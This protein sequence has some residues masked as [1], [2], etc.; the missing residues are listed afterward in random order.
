MYLSSLFLYQS[1][2]QRQLL[3]RDHSL[4]V[5]HDAQLF[6]AAHHQQLQQQEEALL[7]LQGKTTRP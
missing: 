4:R 3:E 7:R 2:S 1:F 6:A 5:A